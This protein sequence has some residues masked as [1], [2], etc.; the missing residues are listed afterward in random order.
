LILYLDTSALVKLYVD[1]EQSDKVR[2]WVAE[3]E[4]VA[5]CKVALPEAMS[6]FARR[7]KAKELSLSEFRRL[8]DA[9]SADW[10]H[11]AV[12][13]FDEMDAAQLAIKHILRGFDAVH[14]AAALLLKR[15]DENTHFGFVSFDGRQNA[16]A[17][18][19]GCREPAIPKRAD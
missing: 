7:H 12:V 19:E 2:E 6:A 9:L 11:Y 1:E 14:L 10:G 16:A 5:T 13:D 4:I 8:K 17:K 3:A 18:A 15:Q